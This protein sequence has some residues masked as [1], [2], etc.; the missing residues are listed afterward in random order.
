[1]T[2]TI[3]DL[4]GTDLLSIILAIFIAAMLAIVIGCIVMLRSQ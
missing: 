4:F 2:I 1:M 3:S